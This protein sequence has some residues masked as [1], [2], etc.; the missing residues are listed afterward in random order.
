[1]YGILVADDEKDVVSLLKDFLEMK[2]YDVLTAYDGKQAVE[3][4]LKYPDLILLDI[5]MPDVNGFD[6]CKKNQRIYF[7]SDFVSYGKSRGFR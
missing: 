1:M 6:V 2:R 4:S 3:T 7:V 5:N